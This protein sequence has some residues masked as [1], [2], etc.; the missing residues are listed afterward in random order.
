MSKRT[1]QPRPQASPTVD[2][3]QNFATR[4]GLGTP[5]TNSASTYGFS[6]ISRDRVKLEFTY[7]SSWIAGRAVDTVAEDMTREGVELLGEIEPEQQEELETEATR[8]KLWPALCDTIR[9]SRL[10]G[11]ALGVLLIDGQD[12]ASPLDLRTIRRGQFKGLL[13][14]D[15]WMVQPSLM[16]LVK[17]MGPDLGMPKFYDVLPATSGLAGAR[18]HYSRV[19]RLG[20]EALPYWQRIA[21]N[22]WGASVLER[23]W[24][25]LIPFD[26]ATEGAAQLVYKAHLR[27]YK[28]KGLREILAVGGAAEKGLRKQMEMV[29]FYQSNEG[30]TLM[31]GEDEFDAHSYSFAGLPDIIT[32]FGQQIS[33]ALDIPLIRLFGQAPAGLSGNHDAEIRNYYDSLKEK[34]EQALRSGVR[35]MYEVLYRSTYGTEPPKGFD[36]KFRPLWQMSENESADVATKT[37]TAVTTAYDAGLISRATALKELRQSSA[38]TGV[39]TNISDEEITEAEN[40][41][42]PMPGELTPEEANG[43]QETPG[44]GPSTES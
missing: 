27:T 26:S 24:D 43:T 17:D 41:P 28:V 19:I 32:Q 22:L 14:L 11:G 6:P 21:E 5:N 23:L 39:F 44:A 35:T 18:L 40:E 38:T 4:T 42:P 12:P 15:R 25:R 36:I 10:Y 8:L 9:W 20:G 7:R 3:F 29:R 2:S 33:G 16:D 13:V 1:R 31:D 30:M 37:T 34:Q